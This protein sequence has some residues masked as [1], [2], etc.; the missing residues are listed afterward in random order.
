MC[1]RRLVTPPDPRVPVGEPSPT[2]R[3]A[4][5]IRDRVGD[6]PP[7][8]PTGREPGAP[9]R[10]DSRFV[11]ANSRQ[12]KEFLPT[13]NQS[14]PFARAGDP[15]RIAGILARVVDRPARRTG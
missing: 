2:G 10:K 12:T 11:G 5:A 8:L 4:R 13:A 3:P 14:S 9:D 6:H 7:R 15:L 1:R